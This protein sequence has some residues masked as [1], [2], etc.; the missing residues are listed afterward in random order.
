MNNTFSFKRL[1][2]LVV[3]EIR[4]SH[5]IRNITIFAILWISAFIILLL[6]TSYNHFCNIAIPYTVITVMKFFAPVVFYYPIL[7]RE[8]RN[9]YLQLPASNLEKFISLAINSFITVPI[10][11][12]VLGYTINIIT[13]YIITGEINTSWANYFY[14]RPFIIYA[15]AII[16]YIFI[17]GLA[18]NK[19]KTGITCL[20]LYY[21]SMWFL[22]LMRKI[23]PT[24]PNEA[25]WGHS[26]E[27]NLYG[28]TILTV[29]ILSLIYDRIK[30][31]SL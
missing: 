3:Y 4:S 28:I 20:A 1:S 13:F 8:N 16:V 5:F 6:N 31:I 21:G 26:H 14:W 17:V 29:I 23:L 10:I 25:T 9:L 2:K 27:A 18:K 24:T 11:I 30:K 12:A 22:T 7:K 19:I 15:T